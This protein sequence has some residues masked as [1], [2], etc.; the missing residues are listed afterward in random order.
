MI[1]CVCTTCVLSLLACAYYSSCGVVEFHCRSEIC[2]RYHTPRNELKTRSF[3]STNSEHAEKV[4][5]EPSLVEILLKTRRWFSPSSSSWSNRAW[6]IIP[7]GCGILRITWS[8]LV[9]WWCTQCRFVTKAYDNAPPISRTLDSRPRRRH[10]DCIPLGSSMERADSGTCRYRE[11]RGIPGNT[12]SPIDLP[13]LP[14]T[15]K[16]IGD[17]AFTPAFGDP[18]TPSR[19]AAQHTQ[20]RQT[21][22]SDRG[23]LPPPLLAREGIVQ[24]AFPS[25]SGGSCWREE[26]RQQRCFTVRD[27]RHFDRTCRYVLV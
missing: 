26:A 6:K 12:I 18:R 7:R 24:D 2:V 25:R 9:C 21:A 19:K 27:C 20:P 15:V 5:L 1:P 14:T 4:G 13:D 3:C 11:A 8:D 23:Q 22:D 10:G 17:L 16:M